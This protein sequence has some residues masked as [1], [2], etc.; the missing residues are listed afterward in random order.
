MSTFGSVVLARSEALLVHLPQVSSAFGSMWRHLEDR[1]GGWQLLDMA[2]PMPHQWP[3][4]GAGPA[5]LAAV[6]G[7]PVLAAF[8]SD[9]SCVQ[10]VGAAPDGR[11]FSSHVVQ[12]SDGKCGYDH[13]RF[14]TLRLP[15]G[16]DP[17]PPDLPALAEDLATWS[18]A[19][20]LDAS[21]R[22]I[23]AT[24]HESGYPELFYDLADALG[25][26]AGEEIDALFDHDELDWYEAWHRGWDAGMRV[27]R[28]WTLAFRATAT[29]QLELPQPGDQDLIG[30]VE[31][32]AN[33]MYG[34]PMTRQDLVEE[35]Y[36]LTSKWP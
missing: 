31:Q 36:R 1:G 22:R 15:V 29:R 33:S 7:A 18:T 14:N 34:G 32:V 8:I 27:C 5:D 30:F 2:P 17:S 9:T 6:T 28:R 19:G 20:G 25:L 21:P 11:S 26:P 13:H 16:V 10:L 3:T 23:R 35:A 12:D 24:L 4:V